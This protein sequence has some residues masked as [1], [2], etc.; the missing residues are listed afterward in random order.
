MAVL[1]ALPFAIACGSD[2]YDLC[3][4]MQDEGCND[5]DH[6]ACVHGCV[7]YD[8][9]VEETDKCED[10]YDEV[11]D[12]VSDL[13]DICEALYDPDKPTEEPECNDEVTDYAEC[14]TD[15]CTDHPN[16]D[17]CT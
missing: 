3:D 16:K 11:L 7:D 9:F 5:F 2:C 12:C 17:W 10:K 1:V 6:G 14:L 13:D 4:D 8:D 15:Y